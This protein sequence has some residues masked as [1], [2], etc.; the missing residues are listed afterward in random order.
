MVDLINVS[1]KHL[2]DELSNRKHVGMLTY[3][4]DSNIDLDGGVTAKIKKGTVIL[5]IDMEG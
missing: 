1:T 5:F 4:K 2:V 3:T